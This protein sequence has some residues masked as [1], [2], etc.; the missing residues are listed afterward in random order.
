MVFRAWRLENAEKV[1]AE[2]SENKRWSSEKQMFFSHITG[3][4]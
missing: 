1:F 2:S 3:D 4:F